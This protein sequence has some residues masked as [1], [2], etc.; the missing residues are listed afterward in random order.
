MSGMHN[1]VYSSEPAASDLGSDVRRRVSEGRGT[2]T[3][4]TTAAT[5]TTRHRD[6]ACGSNMFS[7][8]GR[9][10]VITIPDKRARR[11]ATLQTRTALS[12]ARVHR[13]I[14]RMRLPPRTA[15]LPGRLLGRRG[16]A[17]SKSQEHSRVGDAHMLHGCVVCSLPRLPQLPALPPLPPL[18]ALPFSSSVLPC[19][20]RR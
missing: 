9:S 11:S 19:G 12:R 18:R 15:G 20:L 5:T 8:T 6:V 13:P 17:A 4:T 16:G 7:R 10:S 3:G 14:R 1:P 2:A